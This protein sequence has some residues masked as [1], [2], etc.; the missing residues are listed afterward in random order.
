MTMNCRTQARWISAL[1][2]SALPLA[3]AF[4]G[5][6]SRVEGTLSN[7]ATL[8]ITGDGFGS[9]SNPKPLY[10]FDFSVAAGTSPLGR[11]QYTGQ[12]AGSL[13]TSVVAPGSANSLHNDVAGVTE[14][15]GPRDGVPFNSNTL[16]VWLKKRYGFN[17]VTDRASNGLNL[18]FFRMWDPWTH[19]ILCSYQGSMG[20]DSGAAYAEVTGESANWFRMPQESGKWLAEEYEYLAGDVNATNGIFNYT[21]NG[22][23]AY[24]RTTRF[25]MRTTAAPTTYN[26]LFLDQISNN[27]LSAGK[28]LYYDSLYIDDTWQ[29]VV[30][31]D[32]PQWQSVVYGSGGAE[33]KRE[34]QIPTSWSNT[35]IQIR[36]R[37]GSLTNL[38]GS[39][40]YVIGVD[41]SPVNRVGFPL[42]GTVPNPPTAVQV[43]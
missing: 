32:E 17:I 18:K 38:Q 4:A 22:I 11:Q 16:Y 37:K 36:V 8:T 29:R 6:V 3:A 26:L 5:T 10:W 7:G 2:L 27:Q 35:S 21:R 42:G 1:L 40:L 39:Y 31:S 15:W 12:I 34:I 43:Q 33:R 19:D 30:I 14:A 25:L 9:K 28:N 41:G 20:L 24:P 23:A 13:T